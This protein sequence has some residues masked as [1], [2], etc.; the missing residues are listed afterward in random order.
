MLIIAT[1]RKLE[2]KN[3][4]FQESLGYKVSLRPALLYSKSLSEKNTFP[5]CFEEPL[6]TVSTFIQIKQ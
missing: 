3:Q 1:L 2:K 4:K 6:I 5:F